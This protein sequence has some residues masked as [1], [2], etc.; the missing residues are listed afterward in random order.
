MVT[1]AYRRHLQ[2]GHPVEPNPIFTLRP[3]HGVVMTMHK[4]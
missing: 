4:A 2:P 3:H 1:P